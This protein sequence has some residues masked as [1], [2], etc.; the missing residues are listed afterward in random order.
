[1]PTLAEERT[2][3]TPPVPGVRRESPDRFYEAAETPMA[4]TPSASGD[5]L[6]GAP[7]ERVLTSATAMAEAGNAARENRGLR[8]FRT[9]GG[10]MR[11][12]QPAANEYHSDVV[13][14]LDLVGV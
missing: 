1:M 11:N 2:A 8:R 10:T 7:A 5:Y 13:D 3:G 6:G 4:Q 12:E 9:A 14:L